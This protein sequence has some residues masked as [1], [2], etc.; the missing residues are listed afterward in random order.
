MAIKRKA[1][2]P[3]ILYRYRGT[4]Y[5]LDGG[6]EDLLVHDRIRVPSPTRFNDP[7]DCHARLS[8]VGSAKDRRQFL[9]RLFSKH[10][11][12]LSAS[13]LKEAERALQDSDG[14]FAGFQES[15]D[16]SAVL[17]L[18]DTAI[19]PL[20]WAHYSCGHRGICLGF[21][22]SAPP[23]SKARRVKYQRAYPTANVI[24][25]STLDQIEACIFTK[26]AWW[27]Y[28]R[29]WRVFTYKEPEGYWSIEA[30]ALKS[31]ILGMKVEQPLAKQVCH[32]CQTYKPHQVQVLQAKA[33]PD[34][35]DL[36]LVPL[37]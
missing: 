24:A 25:D 13:E 18:C 35:F 8:F 29:E 4:S 9:A 22:A 19:N 28:E 7:F 2:P 16:N 34:T 17:C 30:D 1:R 3:A 5:A 31:V 32:L 33:G 26:A 21:D 14:I 20:L 37:P 27:R 12:S 36:Q 11:R 15:I 23:F 10:G 6:L